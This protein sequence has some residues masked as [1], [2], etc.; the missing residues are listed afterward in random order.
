M[1]LAELSVFRYK[2]ESCPL[3]NEK[4]RKC[5]KESEKEQRNQQEKTRIQNNI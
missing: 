4:V 1:K 5:T 3:S 2:K